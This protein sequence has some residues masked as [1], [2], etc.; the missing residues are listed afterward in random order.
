[1]PAQQGPGRYPDPQTPQEFQINLIFDE[2]GDEVELGPQPEAEAEAFAQR[3]PGDGG[4]PE[5]VQPNRFFFR[6][7]HILVRDEYLADVKVLLGGERDR[8]GVS[9]V[10]PGVSLLE[11]PDDRGTPT[12]LHDVMAAFGPGIAAHDYLISISNDGFG[13]GGHCPAT[14]PEV[15]PAWTPP[16]PGIRDDRA[17]GDGVR[18]VVIDTGFDAHAVG[19]HPWLQGVTGQPDPAIVNGRVRRLGPYAGHGTFVAG[20]VRSMAPRCQV[21]VRSV[22]RRK[23]AS[24]ESELVRVLYRVLSHDSPDIIT[25]SAGTE[26]HR[27]GGLLSFGAFAQTLLSQHKGVAVVA[28]AGNNGGSVPFWPAAAPWAE[29]VG[30]LAGDWRSRAGFSNHAGWVDVYAPGEDL[31]NA[32]P[33]GEYTY[34]EP[35]LRPGRA[36][37]EGM[38]RWSGTSFSTPL[39]AGLI[40]ARMSRTGENGR[41]AAAALKAQARANA[42]PGVGPILLP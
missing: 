37:F 18:V 21:H 10:T 8:A 38:A 19:L 35:P 30:A 31:I 2:Y 29:G 36:I 4:E 16:D 22:F 13:A 33:V 39:V 41:D 1:M 24:F 11:L 7:G 26:T 40:A 17:A 42:I 9:G 25:M 23:G 6:R 27:G 34:Q 14:E 32:F 3:G 5:P 12:A 20:V 15:V 28:A